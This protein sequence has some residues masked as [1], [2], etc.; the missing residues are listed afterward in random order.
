MKKA[1]HDVWRYFAVKPLALAIRDALGLRPLFYAMPGAQAAWVG[2]G[3]L[4]VRVP[5]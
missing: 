1:P 2:E 3:L 5:R 4:S